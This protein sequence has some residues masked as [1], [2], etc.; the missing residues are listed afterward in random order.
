[1][2]GVHQRV[3]VIVA[4]MPLTGRQDGLIPVAGIGLWALVTGIF[5]TGPLTMRKYRLF[6]DDSGTVVL[7]IE[8]TLLM[9][10]LHNNVLIS[11]RETA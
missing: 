9:T 1:M 6:W 2:N 11:Q 8:Q 5:V 10:V 7:A 3:V 4:D